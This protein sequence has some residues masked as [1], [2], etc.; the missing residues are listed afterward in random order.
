MTHDTSHSDLREAVE[1]ITDK[2]TEPGTKYLR[3][4]NDELLA[5]FDAELTRQVYEAK[6]SELRYVRDK[7]TSD[8]PTFIN[9]QDRTADLK[10]TATNERGNDEN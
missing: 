2:F 9:I 7:L 3:D 1:H 10:R 8:T 4:L 6:I 5:L